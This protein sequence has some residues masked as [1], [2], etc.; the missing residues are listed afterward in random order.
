MTLKAHL[1]NYIAG[2][3]DVK[4][5][6]VIVWKRTRRHLTAFFG[7]EKLLADITAGDAKDF[8]LYLAGRGLAE[9]TIRRTCGIA[10]QFLEDAVDR[11]LLQRNPFK[12]RDIPTAT[13][14]NKTRQA[15][16]SRD[17]AE[18]L[19]DSLPD[20]EWRLLF[21]LSRYG[22]LRC[23]SEHLA[24]RWGDIDWERDRMLVRVSKTE[25]HEG[26]ATRTV[27]IFP[28]L[29]PYLEAVW[30]QAAEGS[31]FVITRY[32]DTNSNLRTALLRYIRRAGVD[33]WPKLFHNL[34]ATRQTELEE[35]FPSHVV[36][37]WLGNSES[38]ARRHYLQVTDDHFAKAVQNPVQQPS[39]N[40]RTA[41]QGRDQAHEETPVLQ[42]HAT[43]CEYLHGKQVGDEG[44]EP[45]TSTV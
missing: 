13:G 16:V 6:T 40:T 7:V 20:A 26:K 38:V 21:A 34:R 41:S 5:N 3:P 27:P 30:E 9:N 10:K 43:N 42:G 8:R 23:P 4:P 11:E 12:H 36:C 31:V 33:P 1:D 24:L 32:R 37:A 15:F 44:L 35:E 39:A 25:H 18:K 28:E 45:P 17:V 14:G 22:G 2:R 29:R 19:M